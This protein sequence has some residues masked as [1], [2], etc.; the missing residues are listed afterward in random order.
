M[1][2]LLNQ[3]LRECNPQIRWHTLALHNPICPW[4]VSKARHGATKSQTGRMETLLEI[5]PGQIAIP[6]PNYL[7]AA[8]VKS[9]SQEEVTWPDM[10]GPDVGI[11]E[12]LAD[13]Y[14][15]AYS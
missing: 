9:S 3:P 11:A 14:D 10:V 8:H 5:A 15:R 1:A 13:M 12:H 4:M 6:L 7:P 2:I